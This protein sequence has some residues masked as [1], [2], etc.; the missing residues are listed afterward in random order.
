[1]IDNT[2]EVKSI[3][4][5]GG[6]SRVLRW[7]DTN[8]N[9]FALK[10]IKNEKNFSPEK[11]EK[12]LFKE[13]YLSELLTGH[14]N[15]LKCLSS[16]TDGKLDT[17]I[18]VL[19]VKYNVL[20]VSPNGSL[21]RFI[22]ETGPVEEEVA[23]FMFIQLAS[24][25]EHMHNKWIAHFDL[26]LE[27]ILL[28]E[29]YNIK[30]A[31]FGSAEEMSST[32]D[33]FKYK[34]GTNWYMA[35]EVANWIPCKTPYSPF[36]AD[37]YSLGI[38]LFLMLLGVFPTHIEGNDSATVASGEDMDI[39]EKATVKHNSGDIQWAGISELSP[40]CRDLLSIMIRKSSIE[41][42]SI[43]QVLAHPWLNPNSFDANINTR[44]YE[45]F[46][47]RKTFISSATSKCI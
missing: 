8:Q 3:L 46:E 45:E 39:D 40:E 23:R 20:E 11:V 36:K 22:R 4:G 19:D 26:K 17:G 1:M 10:V 47:A 38:S 7:V 28:D 12:M 6:S 25:V 16:V 41:R 44:I 37:I 33:L 35:P 32:K 14:P 13:Y 18:S 34:K 5:Q 15:I 31:D 27:N 9:H 24:A 2:F 43:Q 42:P 30:L 21:S 29:Y